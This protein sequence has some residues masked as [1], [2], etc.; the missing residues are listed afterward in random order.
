VN[1]AK[2]MPMMALAL[3]CAIRTARRVSAAVASSTA[4]NTKMPIQ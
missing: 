3:H 1:T 2:N 4:E